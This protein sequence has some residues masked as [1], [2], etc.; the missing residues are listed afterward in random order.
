MQFVVDDAFWQMLHDRAAM[1]GTT[2]TDVMTAAVTKVIEQD[3]ARE[4]RR[5]A[6]RGS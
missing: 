5:A 1:L 4:E 6:R 2:M 3:T